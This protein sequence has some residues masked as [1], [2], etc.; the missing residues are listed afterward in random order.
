MHNVAATILDTARA[1]GEAAASFEYDAL[2]P[3]TARALLKR[4]SDI[5][6][7]Y[8]GEAGREIA[9]A[10]LGVGAAA[11]RDTRIATLATEAWSRAFRAAWPAE[12]VAALAAQ[13]E[14]D[15][16]VV[17]GSDESELCESCEGSGFRGPFG[18][19]PCP[20][21]ANPAT[22]DGGVKEAALACGLSPT[23]VWKRTKRLGIA[24]GPRGGPRGP[25]GP[26]A[27]T[28]HSRPWGAPSKWTAQTVRDAL[29]TAHGSRVAAARLLG[30]SRQRVSQLVKKFN[31]KSGGS[32]P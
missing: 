6:P 11:L 4:G 7:S 8:A 2:T 22:A 24:L 14:S 15:G 12:D 23:S 26:R 13:D 9:A 20:C 19:D 31:L 30:V 16:G 25:G 10:A 18:E 28:A 3:E 29:V 27:R 1:A 32:A 5:V 17:A 21:E